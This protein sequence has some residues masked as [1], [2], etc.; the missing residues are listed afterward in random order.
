MFGRVI[1]L[2]NLIKLGIVVL[3]KYPFV[4]WCRYGERHEL[5]DVTAYEYS[6]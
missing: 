3:L 2:R 4:S 1:F 5:G 6:L